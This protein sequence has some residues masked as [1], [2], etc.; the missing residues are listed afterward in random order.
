MS[1]RLLAVVSRPARRAARDAAL[2]LAA[3]GTAAGPLGGQAEVGCDAPGVLIERAW[4]EYRAGR[5][6][7]AGTRFER[8]MECA[9]DDAGARTGLAYVALRDGREARAREL[10]DQVLARDPAAV[11][12][13]V[14]RGLIAWREADLALTAALAERALALAPENAEARGL[15]DRVADAGWRPVVAAERPPLVVPDTLEYPARTRGDG[16]EI[17]TPDGW[18]PFYVKGINLGAALPGKHPSQFPDSLT[19]ASWIDDMS[20][21]GANVVR[22]YT[23]HPPVFY[24]ALAAHNAAH[25]GRPLWIVHGVWTEL[26][27]DDDYEDEEWEGEFFAEMRRVVDLLHGRAELPARPGHASGAYT[28]DVSRWTL[29]YIIGPNGSPSPW[30][31]STTCGRASGAGAAAT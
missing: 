17:R 1:T 12:A 18:A 14:G 20:A 19:Y 7:A 11:D 26:P 3:L 29:A 27:P 5:L 2:A 4:D 9:P 28:A 15:R 25:P 22:T 13:L 6:D 30:W 10:F 8:A 21:M 31:R 23:I 16:F 24:Q